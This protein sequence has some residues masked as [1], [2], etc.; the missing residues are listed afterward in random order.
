MEFEWDEAKRESNIVKH[1]VDFL[2]AQALFD[3][4]RVITA[5]SPRSDEKRYA[6]TGEIDGRFYTAIWTWR[7]TAVRFISARKARHEEKQRY[8]ALHRRGD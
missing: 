5:A 2:R 1:D 8:L 7:G 3:G 6:T 4:R